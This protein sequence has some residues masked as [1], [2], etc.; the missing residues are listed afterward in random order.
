MLLDDKR[1]Q[2]RLQNLLEH[3]DWPI[4]VKFAEELKRSL[5]VAPVLSET[6]WDHTKGSLQKEYQ[7][8]FID[9]F[10]RLLEEEAYEGPEPEDE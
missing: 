7:I 2:G 8:T 1:E 3:A 4:L 6:Q 10:L 9:E 5:G